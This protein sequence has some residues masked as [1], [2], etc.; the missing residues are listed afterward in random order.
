PRASWVRGA[1]M[2]RPLPTLE[3]VAA[4]AGPKPAGPRPSGSALT[5][6]VDGP[7]AEADT[8]YVTSTCPDGPTVTSPKNPSAEPG[9]SSGVMKAPTVPR[10]ETGA[11]AARMW[12]P[13]S[14]SSRRVTH[15]LPGV[16]LLAGPV[17]RVGW[18]ESPRGPN[19]EASGVNVVPP[20]VLR[21]T[22]TAPTPSP[23]R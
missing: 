5:K 8:W 13:K 4:T 1:G 14:F 19:S 16:P 17:R 15:T 7:A 20:S 21:I 12:P 18:S 22:R 23:A 11:P 9:A 10:P 6:I 2:R 3:V